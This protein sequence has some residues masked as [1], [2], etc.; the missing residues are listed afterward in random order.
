MYNG[1]CLEL[2]TPSHALLM[3]QITDYNDIHA[4]LNF[5]FSTRLYSCC[6]SNVDYPVYSIYSM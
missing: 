1:M 5:I 2:C 3:R 6:K 4:L